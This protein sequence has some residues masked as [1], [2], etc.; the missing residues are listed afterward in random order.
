MEILLS[1]V[2]VAVVLSWLLLDESV[3]SVQM[4][5]GG[6]VVGGIAPAR[7]GAQHRTRT[8]VAAAQSAAT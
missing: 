4:I 6:L 5:G 7:S 8:P 2:L 1:E 3:A